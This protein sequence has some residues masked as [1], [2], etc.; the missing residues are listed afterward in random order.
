[1]SQSIL[2]L[3]SLAQLLRV[4]GRLSEEL[5]LYYHAQV[6]QALEHL[7]SR[8]V[9]H[10]DV[11]GLWHGHGYGFSVKKITDW[12]TDII[13][14]CSWQR[15]AVWGWQTV[16]SVWFRALWDTQPGRIQHQNLQRWL[17]THTSMHPCL[18]IKN[19]RNSV[20]GVCAGNIL[21]GTESHMPPEVARATLALLKL[22]SG[23]A[24]VLLHMLSGHQPWTR[25][26]PH[27]LYLKVKWACSRCVCCLESKSPN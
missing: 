11:K 22:T 25:Y 23:A 12:C 13:H 3:G 8:R 27:P 5:A 9:V 7:H 24:A 10:L 19:N 20:C 26:H 18:L 2:S 17:H 21:R 4:R 1:M 15:V 6:L 16:F 14:V